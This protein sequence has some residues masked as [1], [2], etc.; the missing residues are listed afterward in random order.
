MRGDV[1][2]VKGPVGVKRL[3]KTHLVDFRSKPD[4]SGHVPTICRRPP[5]APKA[6]TVAYGYDLVGDVRSHGVS[7]LRCIDHTL[8]PEERARRRA[9]RLLD[10]IRAAK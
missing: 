2:A 10:R 5:R 1:P 9:E 4:A 3:R 6:R 8:R 7:C